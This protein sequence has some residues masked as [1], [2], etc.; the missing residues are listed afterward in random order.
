MAADLSSMPS[1]VSTCRIEVSLPAGAEAVQEVMQLAEAVMATT[2]E[3]QAL[4]KPA[5]SALPGMLSVLCAISL[6]GQPH[7]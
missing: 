7:R 5:A 2:C 6:P 4:T 1:G 3:M